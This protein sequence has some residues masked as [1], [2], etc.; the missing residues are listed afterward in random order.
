MTPEN[1][2]DHWDKI[3]SEIDMDYIPLEYINTVIVKF[4]DG[5]EWEIDI[6]KS[7]NNVTDVETILDDFFKE[8]ENRIDTVDF[9]LNLESLKRDV[10]KRTKRFLKVNK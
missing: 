1:R 8:Y 4:V 10:D 2:D 5:K 3:L 7:Q 9:R 6:A